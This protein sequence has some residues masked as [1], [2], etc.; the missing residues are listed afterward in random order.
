[1]TTAHTLEDTIAWEVAR[2]G[3]SRRDAASDWDAGPSI[4]DCALFQSMA[5]F[6]RF[7]VAWN[8]DVF[9]SLPDGT[10]HAGKAGLQRGDVVL[11]NWNGGVPDHTEMALMSPDAGGNFRTIGV[12]G[13]DTIA[14]AYRIRNGYVQ[15]YFRP[16][17]APAAVATPAAPAPVPKP[18]PTPAERHRKRN[19]HMYGFMRRK[20]DG[21]LVI[22]N[23]DAKTY[24]H[25]SPG[26]WAAYAA[27]GYAYADVDDSSYAYTL[28]QLTNAEPAAA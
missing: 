3:I 6:G 27:Q 18:K 25:L 15:G 11:F 2:L 22:I 23:A 8:V 1:M 4:D 26:E 14:C 28:S 16:N 12:N 13:S 19:T 5:V 20:S 17:Y 9:E 10:Y 21:S 7:G 24:R